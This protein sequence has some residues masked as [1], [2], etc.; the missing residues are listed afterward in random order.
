[1]SS[2]LA[3]LSLALR[4]LRKSPGFAATIVA[5]L[6]LGVGANTAIFS[7][8]NAVL[9]QPFPYP[10][11][12]QL[13]FIGTT[14]EGQQGISPMTF[15]EYQDFAAQLQTVE[16]LAWVTNRNLTMTAV[17]EPAALNGAAVT[18]AAW[19]MLGVE[20]MLGRTFTAAEDRPGA[21]PVVVLSAATWQG[22]FGRDPSI[23]GREI[24]LDGRAFTVVGVMPP[25]CRF[26]GAE[27]WIPAGLEADTELMRN[28][29]M[30]MNT[31]A[32][33]RKKTGATL[34]EVNTELGV[35]ASRIAAQ[36]PDTNRNFGAR[37]NLLAESVTG[38]V[39]EPLLMLLGAVAFVL[40]IACANV[41]NLL[42]ARSATRQ[43]EFS[44]RA[45]LGAGRTR[46]IRQ[47]LLEVLPLAVLGS[48]AGI[49]AAIWGLQA[50]LSLLPAN[51]IPAEAEI[52]MNLPVMLLS[53]GVCL[54][55]MLLFALLPALELTRSQ[56]TAVLQEAG[57]R[58][59]GGPRSGRVRAALIVAEISLSLILLVGAGLLIRSF[60]KLQ[61]VEPGFNPRNLLT[62]QLQLPESRYPHSVQAT[63]FY[64][65]LV[66]R[67]RRLPG[68][69]AVAASNNAP[70]MNGSGIPLLTP[71]KTYASLNELQSVQFHGV[72][73]DYFAAQGLRLTQGRVFTDADRAGS[74][75]V[76][77]LNEE[78]V[79][80]FLPAGTNPIGQR[81]M[82]GLPENLITPGMLPP[83]L[84]RF[85]WSTVV[86]VVA[87]ARHFGLRND[88]IP[89]AYFP[90][91]QG[92]E[93]PFLRN[94]LILLV[95]TAGD[96]LAVAPSVRAAVLAIDA[97][98]PLGRIAEFETIIAESLSQSRFGTVL[99]GLF[100]AVAAALAVVGIYGVVAWNV[101]QR[102]RELGIR[103]ALGATRG[104]TVRLVLGHGLRVVVLGVLIGLGGSLA[105]ARVLERMLYQTSPF[106]PWIFACVAVAL[107]LVALTACLVPALRAS[108][109]SPLEALHTE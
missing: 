48:A 64:R 63:Q 80:R 103:A 93:A 11:S 104:D 50:L 24:I 92:W 53:L 56:F 41:A 95:R 82:L 90:I 36:Y 29:V 74:E 6:A 55:T 33:G 83:G 47:V 13:L 62:T 97:N 51:A 96:P 98:Q 70:F 68:V 58:S 45:A 86:G 91:E 42:L 7:V 8:I 71:D 38:P 19:P 46:L 59:S 99:L 9:L 34:E 40:L 31:W 49:L 28:R 21:S 65:D 2:L 43:R 25:R 54:G 78:A 32:F 52:T 89:A 85:H 3:D 22:K 5:I 101:A 12:E 23:L 81:V 39:R 15:P 69:Q 10:R 72:L 107:V 87:S 77:I 26:S 35:I 4:L 102:T 84:D 105:L 73:G 76:V 44:V 27:V 75:P 79:K 17:S 108:R 106:D 14:Q 100:A 18:A 61:S 67:V 30:R 57:T 60:G 37:A 16:H 1:M 88:P 94:N 109:V 20:P 66:E